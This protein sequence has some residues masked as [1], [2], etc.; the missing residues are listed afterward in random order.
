MPDSARHTPRRTRSHG[1]WARLSESIESR[2][3]P[4]PLAAVILSVGLGLLLPRVDLL[5][6]D[7]LPDAVDSVVFN[8]GADSARSVLS[9]IAGSLITAT[10]LTFSLTVI[11]LQL[12]SSQGS[13]RVLRL[14]ARDRQV[15]FTLAAFLGTF[16]YSLT[17]LRTVRSD[18]NGDPP[19]IPRI[20]VTVA[21]G[22]TLLSVVMLV[23]FLAH[24]AAQLRI[25]TMLRD[26]HGETDSTIDLVS[27]RNAEVDAFRGDVRVPTL[28]HP[29]A[30]PSSGFITNLDHRE[31]VALA[32]QRE[33]VVQLS[34]KVGDSVVAGTPLAHWWPS[35]ADAT[36]D[37]DEVESAVQSSFSIGYERTAADDVDFGLQ[38][39]IDIG[40]R[41]LSPGLNDPTTAVHALGH[42]TAITA[43]L[44]Q[45]PRLPEALADGDG[46]LCVLT[47]VRSP[48]DEIDAALTPIRHYGAT[49]PSVTTRFLQ[50]VSELHL[51]TDDAEVED[52]LLAQLDAL[53]AQLQSSDGDPATIDTMLS[54]TRETRRR[55]IDGSSL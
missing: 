34:R 32:S 18:E 15:H 51:L 9:A 6:D 48:A 38:Q 50:A 25:E 8:G 40:L 49:H 5:V 21:F 14:F 28:K 12:A 41:A 30:A 22:L 29:V 52:A 35:R 11:A 42:L 16:A 23:F 26:I 37:A 27:G 13:P 31:L 39:T 17:V 1:W 47:V 24:L 54:Q 45:I 33:V 36:A 10:S 20:S 19:F 53:T 44:L 3:W 4:L 46:R 55:L 2:L 7:S 43:R